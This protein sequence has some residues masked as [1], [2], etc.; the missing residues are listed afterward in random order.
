VRNYLWELTCYYNKSCTIK[1]RRAPARHDNIYRFQ[2]NYNKDFRYPS[3]H[4]L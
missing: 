1:I 3:F 2:T 4:Y